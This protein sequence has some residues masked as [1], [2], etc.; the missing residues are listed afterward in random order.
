MCII[1][2]MCVCLTTQAAGFDA[3]GGQAAGQ[4]GSEGLLSFARKPISLKGPSASTPRGGAPSSNYKS[5]LITEI[6]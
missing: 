5:P 6:S 1:G 3:M 2:K 4:P